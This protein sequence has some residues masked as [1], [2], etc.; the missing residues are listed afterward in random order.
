MSNMDEWELGVEL[1]PEEAAGLAKEF[2]QI[3][4]LKAA[5][6]GSDEYAAAYLD[7]YGVLPTAQHI[8][9]AV[10]RRAAPS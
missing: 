2:A 5:L 4:R 7:L 1:T 9:N 3:D 10:E 6:P 8:A